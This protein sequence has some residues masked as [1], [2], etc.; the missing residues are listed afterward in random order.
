MASSLTSFAWT[1]PPTG[2]CAERDQIAA[3]VEHVL[4]H[5]PFAP[6]GAARARVEVRVEAATG[7]PGWMAR[8][9]LADAEGRSIGV[10]ELRTTE[11]SCHALDGPVALV[12]ALMVEASRPEPAPLHV[13]PTSPPE[14]AVSEPD[15]RAEWRMAAVGSGGLLPGFA[16]GAQLAVGATPPGF[17]PIVAAVTLWPGA[18]RT[19]AERGGTFSAWHAGLS[20]CPP[21]ASNDWGGV[22]LCVG[23][24]AGVLSAAGVGLDT[25]ASPQR[26]LVAAR[27]D[28]R[29]WLAL[30][31]P[32]ILHFQAGAV[33]PFIRPNY[34]YDGPDGAPVEVHRPW[35]VVPVGAAGLGFVLPP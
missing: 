27:A 20:L 19:V 31:G 10:R 11:P 18:D 2:E 3:D 1:V 21:L 28:A 6:A 13:P 24:E 25:I 29:A 35:P 14:P 32:F 16:L 15:W 12:A 5:S 8:I 9:S 30:G 17:V 33:V 34:L 23:A 26:P 4:G 22:G 7:T